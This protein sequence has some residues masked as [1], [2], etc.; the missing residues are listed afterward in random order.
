MIP[1]L[2]TQASIPG[3]IFLFYLHF[4]YLHFL[5]SSISKTK[6]LFTVPDSFIPFHYLPKGWCYILRFV[7]SQCLNGISHEA[8]GLWWNP[9]HPG[10]SIRL[11]S[12]SFHLIKSRTHSVRLYLIKP[13]YTNL[14]MVGNV[15][16]SWRPQNLGRETIQ[17]SLILMVETFNILDRILSYLGEAS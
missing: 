8:W 11:E 5:S 6:T 1:S 17:E 10:K 7:S 13:N 12:C 9:Q 3:I 16:L 4:L 14:L 15:A 2:L